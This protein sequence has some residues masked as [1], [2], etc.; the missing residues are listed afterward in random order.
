[1]IDF[2][3]NASGWATF[4]YT[5]HWIAKGQD[6]IEDFKTQGGGNMTSRRFQKMSNQGNQVIYQAR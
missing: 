3:K 5:H 6:H 1:M 2:Y 4:S